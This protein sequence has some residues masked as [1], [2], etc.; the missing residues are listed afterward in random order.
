M[1][2][3]TSTILK[4]EACLEYNCFNWTWYQKKGINNKA[5]HQKKYNQEQ[6]TGKLFSFGLQMC[7]HKDSGGYLAL[8]TCTAQTTAAV[9]AS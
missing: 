8:L 4:T 6:V 7:K 2:P 5:T 1:L 3:I 9:Q